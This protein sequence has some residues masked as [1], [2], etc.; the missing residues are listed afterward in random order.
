M[1]VVG[2]TPAWSVLSTPSS[3]HCSVYLH[4]RWS[5]T[6]STALSCIAFYSFPSPSTAIL[7]WILTL[8]QGEG[9]AGV[10]THCLSFLLLKINELKSNNLKQH[11][12]IILIVLDV[13][14]QN[15]SHWEEVKVS[16]GLHFSLRD[17]GS[18]LVSCVFYFNRRPHSLAP[19]LL[20]S[21]K[22]AMDHSLVHLML[23][24]SDTASSLFHSLKDL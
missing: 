16:A 5:S 8:L 18:H 11:N 24:S 15:G 23:Y 9:R 7:S 4:L 10:I 17:P 2:Q 21:S 13:R 20:P 3:R 19:G 22:P 12:C 1:Q 6:I 14:A